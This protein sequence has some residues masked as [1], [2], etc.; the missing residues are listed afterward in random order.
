MRE[1]EE[2]AKIEIDRLIDR[3]YAVKARKGEV[4]RA[5]LKG[6]TISKLGL[7]VKTK[8][9]GAKK[10]RIII[11]LRRS[12]GNR[13]A[14]LPERLI[15]P[16]PMDAITMVRRMH[17]SKAELE[18]PQDKTLELVMIDVSDAYMH[19][20]VAEEEKGHCLA[21]ALDDEHW[22]LF[23]ALLFGFKTAPLT[24]SRAAACVARL[25]QSVIPAERGTHQVYL[26]DSLW[27]LG[28]NGQAA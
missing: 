16:R 25:L 24:W 20:A 22:L 2:D 3:G 15:L 21:P 10:R 8:E 27:V 1:Q 7:I 13:K 26:D 5:G 6:T 18:R 17:A 28:G 14:V 11:D 23:I 19:L 12:G 9:G 4:E